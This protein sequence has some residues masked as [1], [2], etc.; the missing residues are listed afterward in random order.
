MLLR[1]VP[2]WLASPLYVLF[3]LR[4]RS[5]IAAVDPVFESRCSPFSFMGPKRYTP[6]PCAATDIPIVDAIIISHSHYDH[7]SHPTVL[8]LHKKH[9]NAYFLVGLGLKKW[10][11]DCGIEKVVEMDWWNDVEM[12]L[13][14]SGEKR[15]STASSTGT[16][17]TDDLKD[18]IKA[19]ISCL[20][21]Q[22]T[23]AR[24]PFDYATTLWCSWAVSSGG[25]SVW[26]GGD[27]GYRTVPELPAGECHSSRRPS[28]SPLS[29]F[30]WIHANSAPSRCG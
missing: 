12:S 7:L 2:Y 26:F 6:P 1:R 18:Q 8:A 30:H 3:L 17:R 28:C 4:L 10:F 25:K 27:T 5:L 19:T 14:P 21:C 23:S 9:P 11:N 15:I 24:T 29:S 16:G 22:H 20:P 13:S